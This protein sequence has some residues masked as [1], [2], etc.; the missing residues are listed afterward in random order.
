MAGSR[1]ALRGLLR[2]CSD[3]SRQ[4]ARLD[5]HLGRRPRA[6][7]HPPRILRLPAVVRSPVP[8]L[9]EASLHLLIPAR[10]KALLA[11]LCAILIRLGAPGAH[12]RVDPRQFRR[13]FSICDRVHVRGRSLVLV[14][15]APQREAPLFAGSLVASRGLLPEAWAEEIAEERRHPSLLLDTFLED[16]RYGFRLIRR[17]PLLSAVIF[18]TLTVGIGINASVFTVV[19][20]LALRPHVY[21]APDSFV[22]VVPYARAQ[23]QWRPVSYPEYS[24]LANQARSLRQLAAYTMFQAMIGDEDST[25]VNGL[26]VSCNFF[27]VDGTERATLGRVLVPQDC[28][29]GTAAPV[30]VISESI[31]HSRFASDPRAIG[32]TIRVNNHPLLVIGVVPDRTSNW[33]RVGGIW[34]PYTAELVVKP[35]AFAQESFLWLA[36]AGRLAPGYSRSQAEAELQI[37]EQRQDSLNPG[38]RTGVRITDG[39]WA[40]ELDLADAGRNLMLFAFFFGAFHLVLFISCANVATLLLS[41]AAAR[42]REIAVRLSLGAPRVRLVRML[43]TES[44]IL[45][46]A[47]GAISLY[48]AEKVPHP[49]YRMVASR[50]PDFP[51]PTDWR[52]FVYVFALVMVTGFLA[53]LAPALESLKLDLTGTLKGSGGALTGGATG[54]RVR[55]WLV[56]AQ[57]AMS[58]VLVVEAGLFGQSEN[59]ALRAD[60]GYLPQRVVVAPIQFPDTV[61]PQTAQVRLEAMADR[62]RAIPGVHSVSFSDDLPL[63]RP[64]TLEIVPPL[65]HDALQPV[66]VFL[67]SAHFLETM[68]IPVLKGRDF[69]DSDTSG[70]VISNS[71]ARLLFWR[72]QN[73]VGQ[74]LTFPDGAE[75]IIGVARDIEPLRVGGSDNPPVYRRHPFNPRWNAMSVRFDS[76]AAKGAPAVRAA[77]HQADPNSA[78]VSR[79]LQSWIDEVTEV[80]WNVAALIAV[81]GVVATVLTTTGIY[82]AVSFA[83]NQKTRDLGIRVALGASRLD[84]V[85]EVFLSGGKPVIYGLLLGLWFSVAAATGLRESVKGSPIRLDTTE[86]LLYGGTLLLIAIAAGVAMLGPARRGSRSDPLEALRCE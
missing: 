77:I 72:Q 18:L 41:R 4:R 55:G 29:V 75:P 14:S 38:R 35:N 23:N 62:V 39:S 45:A 26:L 44:F 31:W 20:S 67:V 83:V 54:T 19:N 16:V 28:D 46:A 59:R 73:P 36:L 24:A 47:A 5:R 85:R 65:R 51:M 79:L 6:G 69:Q 25:G 74:T 78:V 34:V 21:H 3:L 50:A 53:G 13:A 70:V 58:M 84:I 82:G 86:P 8:Q 43:I 80:L 22:R 10:Q 56:A 37:L 61:S 63:L 15:S 1:G 27:A 40:A 32:R 52:T 9:V 2:H 71:L 30:A 76:G 81:L 64:E 11:H 17:S 48:L 49:L 57:V 66:D 12:R 42:R 68:G 60:P 33:T 7:R